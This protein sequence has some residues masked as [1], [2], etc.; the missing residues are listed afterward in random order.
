[1]RDPRW[2]KKR[3]QLLESANWKCQDGGCRR[4]LHQH[5]EHLIDPP[6][7]D[8][9]SLEIHHLYYE[10]G[11]DPWDY[12]DDAFLVLCD[13][14]HDKRSVVERKLKRELACHFRRCP[15]DMMEDFFWQ[16]LAS[17]SPERS[18]IQRQEAEP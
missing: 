15:T 1:L 13:E 5:A 7:G 9:P 17:I 14:C 12:P 11:R 16:M 2:Q 8:P 6:P 10:R 18:D 4:W 3:L